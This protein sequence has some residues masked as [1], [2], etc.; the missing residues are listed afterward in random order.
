M[1]LSLH[2]VEI[3]ILCRRYSSAWAWTSRDVQRCREPASVKIG[4]CYGVSKIDL[5]MW[6]YSLSFILL[7]DVHRYRG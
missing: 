7:D 3:L 2:V 1:A 4:S 6:G 5:F